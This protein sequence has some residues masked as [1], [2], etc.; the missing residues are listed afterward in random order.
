MAAATRALTID[1]F[2]I[3]SSDAAA[4]TISTAPRHLRLT[5]VDVSCAHRPEA[6]RGSS[7]A[8]SCG[9]SVARPS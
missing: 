5:P 1:G 4:G 9:V 8:R 6:W 7:I 3:T 2:D